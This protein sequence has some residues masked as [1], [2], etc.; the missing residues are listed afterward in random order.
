MSSY[1]KSDCCGEPLT[2]LFLENGGT[3]AD[4]PKCKRACVAV[5][6]ID[7]PGGVPKDIKQYQEDIK[8]GVDVCGQCGSDEC[9]GW[10]AELAELLDENK[11]TKIRDFVVRL[12]SEQKQDMLSTIKGL[13]CNPEN[14]SLTIARILNEL[15]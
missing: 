10:Q 8:A 7:T 15:R 14:D 13:G 5:A 2:P 12:L 6:V 9:N 3:C 1:Y 4:C 11:P